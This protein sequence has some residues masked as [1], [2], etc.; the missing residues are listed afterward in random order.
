VS[1]GGGYYSL[2]LYL[3]EVAVR[4]GEAIARGQVVGSVGGART[5]EGAHIEFQIRSPGGE[6]VDPL[7]WL[8]ARSP[9]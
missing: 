1:H 6:A 2:Y 8:R 7:T 9:A 5:P 3:R 4:E